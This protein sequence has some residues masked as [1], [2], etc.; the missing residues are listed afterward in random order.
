MFLWNVHSLFYESVFQ[1]SLRVSPFKMN[2]VVTCSCELS[3]EQLGLLRERG[4]R[5]QRGGAA[6]G[7]RRHRGP[8]AARDPRR[9]RDPSGPRAARAKPRRRHAQRQLTHAR[10][11]LFRHAAELVLQPAGTYSNT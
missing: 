4:L 2:F 6:R 3:V 9:P 7:P 10:A 8:R 11:L 5:G 1:S